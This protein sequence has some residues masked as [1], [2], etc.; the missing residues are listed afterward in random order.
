MTARG[1]IVL[2]LGGYTMAEQSLRAFIFLENLVFREFLHRLSP[3][4]RK[5]M[6]TNV[7]IPLGKEVLIQ[8]VS[9]LRKIM[10]NV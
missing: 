9:L 7:P 1:L 5:S 6:T 10:S 8:K 3:H 2:L 4:R